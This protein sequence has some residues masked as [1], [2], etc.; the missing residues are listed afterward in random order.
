MLKVCTPNALWKE[1]LNNEIVE[2]D[3]EVHTSKLNVLWI[4][5]AGLGVQSYLR[6]HSK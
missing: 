1:H 3:G 4:E 6:I 2:P 5:V